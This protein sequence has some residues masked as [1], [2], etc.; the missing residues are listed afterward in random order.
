MQNKIMVFIMSLLITVTSFMFVLY[1]ERKIYNPNGSME[2]Y[3]VK[4]NKIEKGYVI[5]KN[6][7][8]SLFKL[9]ERRNEQIV[10]SAITNKE[11]LINTIVNQ[12]MYK[13]EVISSN[14]LGKVDD[15]LGKIE[16]KREISINGSDVAEVVGGELREGD[17]V[18]IMTTYAYSSK[19]VT[20]TKIKSAYITK[21]YTSDGTLITRNSTNK[22]AT[23]INLI[24]SA[25]DA[26]E[27]ENAISLGKIK[28]VKVLDDT[29]PGQIR[30]ENNKH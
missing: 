15:E 7:F 25:K 22:A 14:M 19:I 30:I 18:D 28:L 27:L 5:N 21:T 17:K 1:I 4:V 2:V 11:N 24:V 16:N 13:S 20:E 12:E 23:I 9:E 3:V 6:N 29:D 10:P 26:G 8:D